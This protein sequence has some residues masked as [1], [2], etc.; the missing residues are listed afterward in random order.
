MKLAY[1]GI[2]V[3]LALVAFPGCAQTPERPEVPQAHRQ[4]VVEGNNRFALD[5]YNQLAKGEDGNLFISPFS[6]STALAMTSAGARG[7]TEAQMA[8]VLHLPLPQDKLHAAYN[9]LLTDLNNRLTE[10]ESELRVA[11]SLWAQEDFE[12][13]E[14]FIGLLERNY[15]AGLN[16]VN[17]KS[18]EGRQ[19]ACELV[20]E[21]VE[22][23]TGGKIEDLVQPDMLD[24]LTRLILTN[25]IYFKGSWAEQ[26]E[27]RKTRDATFTL[28]DGSEIEVPTMH[29]STKFRFADVDDAKVLELPYSD[30]DLSMVILLPDQHDGL[31]ELEK[32]LTFAK[33]KRI[34]G[35][36]RESEVNVALP[37]FTMT[38]KAMLEG[39][40]QQMGMKDAFSLPPADFSGMTGAKDLVIQHIVHKAFVE[41]NEEGTE[42]A[43]ATG[44][45]VG[46]TSVVIRNEFRANHPFLFLIRDG[47]T[48]SILFMGRVANPAAE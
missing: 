35:S 2:F 18:P 28:A 45:I 8:E 10:S 40:L 16:E 5:L 26:F 33:L 7:E 21:W 20:N 13:L 25:A 3:A 47:K 41:V 31:R 17:F 4:A 11:N 23:R 24:S 44:V 42:A 37:R 22:E 1:R 43:G 46:K 38:W 30:G 34:L 27:E 12:F 6:V 29:Q 32:S 9:H 14:K 19:E 39:P 48:G 15:D 36:L